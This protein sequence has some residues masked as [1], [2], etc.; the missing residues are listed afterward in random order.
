MWLDHQ[1][2]LSVTSTVPWE[3]DMPHVAV[4]IIMVCCWQTKHCHQAI[5]NCRFWE[6]DVLLSAYIGGA[7]NHTIK[8]WV[9]VQQTTVA[10]SASQMKKTIVIF[11]L[12]L[13][14]IVIRVKIIIAYVVI[15][16]EKKA[17]GFYCA[18]SFENII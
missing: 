17:Q 14:V 12:L 9:I 6:A 3:E 10:L 13:F 1:Q 11:H 5:K 15:Y 4:I 16:L 7:Y 8:C 2:K 18:S